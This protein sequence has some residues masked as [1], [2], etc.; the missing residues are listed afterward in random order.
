MINELKKG[1]K[2]RLTSGDDIMIKAKL[3]EG[4]QGRVYKVEYK[5]KEYALK[6]YFIKKIKEP[7]RFYEN[8]KNNVIKGSPSKEF[9][10]PLAITEEQN[11]SF[12]YIMDL[13]PKEYKDFIHFLNAVERYKDTSTVVNAGL[14]MINAFQALHRKGYSYQDL[15]DGNFFINPQNGD[16][17]ICDNDNV[18]PYGESFGVAGKSR[19]MA[20]EI[21]LGTGR[22]N[23]DADLFSLSVILF[24]LIFI[25]HPLEGAKVIACPC[26]T[27]AFEVN[28][29]AE[30]PIFVWDPIDTTNRPV[31]G[32][33]NNLI[34]LWPL[35]PEYLH[36]AFIQSFGKGSKDINS[37]LRESEWRNIF[38]KLKDDI[39]KC[40]NCGEENFANINNS[41]V[42]K[43]CSCGIQT[44]RPLSLINDDF[45]IALFPGKNI[46]GWHINDGDYLEIVGTVVQNKDNPN[47]WGIRNLSDILWI[48]TNHKGEEKIKGKNEVVP[49]LKDIDIKIG[50]Q[51]F[52]I[53]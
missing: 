14:N 45:D 42:I 32:I 48:V 12:G 4:G 16:I 26:L 5:G 50:N 18:S 31:R 1:D 3:G 44:N 52:I 51:R 10:W 2:I 20:P 35:F 47:L 21:V 6:W 33:H 8:L 40:N 43:C 15:N 19:Y 28:L 23:L 11:G 9:L 36:D 29:Y 53:K 24:M 17:L 49:V 39:V 22:P 41:G 46:T 34:N 27:E 25:A 13:R 7:K 30:K 37:R 38:L